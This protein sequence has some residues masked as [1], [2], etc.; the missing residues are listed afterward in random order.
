MGLYNDPYDRIGNYSEEIFRAC[1]LVVD[2]GMHALGWTREQAV[3]YMKEHSAASEENINSEINRYITWPGQAVGYKIGEIKLKEL[4]KEAEQKLGNR[5][6]IKMFHEVV[7]KSAGPIDVV[8]QE[9][10][11]YIDMKLAV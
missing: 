3:E 8:S 2:T 6:D 4:R 1:R 10:K 5:F 11:S 9:V 7:L